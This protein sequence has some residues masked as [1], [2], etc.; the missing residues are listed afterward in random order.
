MFH[1]KLEEALKTLSEGMRG[2]GWISDT[3]QFLGVDDSDHIYEA[4]WTSLEINPEEHTDDLERLKIN[5][6]E[7]LTP[8]ATKFLLTI[9]AN[10][11]AVQFLAQNSDAR[12]YA[13]KNL[14]W[15]RTEDDSC[16]VWGLDE[17]KFNSILDYAFENVNVK[18]EG[19]LRILDLKNDVT[20]DI[21][22]TDMESAAFK[23]L[24]HYRHR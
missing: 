21:P 10:K 1:L 6:G 22:F 20:Y 17:R 23:D 3:G 4:F 7:K 16:Q 13:F 14:N 11:E 15:I 9:G 19:E 5:P 18:E 2:E 24:A 8:E 12:E